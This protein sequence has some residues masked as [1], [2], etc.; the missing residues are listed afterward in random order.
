MTACES[1]VPASSRL[2]VRTGV[3]DEGAVVPTNFAG[4]ARAGAGEPEPM[5]PGLMERCA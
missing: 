4:V 5:E 3:H 2:V 1:A